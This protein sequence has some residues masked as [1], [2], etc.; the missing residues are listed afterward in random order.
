MMSLE[1]QV[2][3]CEVL[4]ARAERMGNYD[5]V[6]RLTEYENTLRQQYHPSRSQNP[7]AS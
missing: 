6:R 1:Y 5:A 7:Q 3:D 2:Y 4:I